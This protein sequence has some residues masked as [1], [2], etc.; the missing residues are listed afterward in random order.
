MRILAAA[1]RL[2]PDYADQVGAQFIHNAEP[3][4]GTP[5][6]IDYAKAAAEQALREASVAAGE[7]ELVVSLSIS[8]DHLSDQTNIMGPRLC[9]PLQRELGADQAVVF[10]L[11]DACWSFALETTYSF[12]LGLGFRTALLVRAEC[13]TGLDT[14]AALP[15][16][17]GAGAGALVLRRDDDAPWQA[18]YT[19]L[20]CAD[21][22]AR[23]EL[24]DPRLRFRGPYRAALYFDPTDALQESLMQTTDRLTRA[25]DAPS[26]PFIEPW[27]LRPMPDMAPLTPYAFPLALAEGAKPDG[28]VT[29]DPFRLQLGLCK[30]DVQ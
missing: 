15:L 11:H 18:D 28:L 1:A 30:V 20:D 29:F 3:L 13:P 27:A 19:A 9:H 17:W 16:A 24:L 23:M 10:D 5:M 7:L 8:P 4:F 25:T 2:A 26:A 22:P 12:M 14:R 21:D 6:A